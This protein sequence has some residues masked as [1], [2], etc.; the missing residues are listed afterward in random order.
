[1]LRE[2]F[3]VEVEDLGLAVDDARLPVALGCG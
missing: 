1:V 3:R 2:H